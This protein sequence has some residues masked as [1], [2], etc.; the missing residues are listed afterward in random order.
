ML[1]PTLVSSFEEETNIKTFLKYCDFIDLFILY[2][3]D[4]VKNLRKSSSSYEFIL[5]NLESKELSEPNQFYKFH[6]EEIANYISSFG[7]I[8]RMDLHLPIDNIHMNNSRHLKFDVLKIIPI[9]Y[10]ILEIIDN[11]ICI[12]IFGKAKSYLL[13]EFRSKATEEE[14]R[15]YKI[16]E[17]YEKA[18]NM[19]DI[20]AE[21]I[22]RFEQSKNYRQY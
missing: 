2:P 1:N 19:A 22:R 20:I 3:P 12:A 18:S 14:A 11:N 9:C 21:G 13:E 16:R 17:E 7:L 4:V 8:N 6:I 10:E 15:I 5:N